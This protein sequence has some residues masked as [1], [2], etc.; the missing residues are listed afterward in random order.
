MQ[1]VAVVVP[2]SILIATILVQLA[3]TVAVLERATQLQQVCRMELMEPQPPA[4]AVAAA[5]QVAPV[6]SW[7]EKVDLALF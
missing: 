5:E 2:I 6:A 7:A 3:A 4:V 1:V